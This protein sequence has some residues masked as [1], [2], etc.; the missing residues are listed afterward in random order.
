MNDIQ[1]ESGAG[2]PSFLP[3]RTVGAVASQTPTRKESFAIT[4]AAHAM[5]QGFLSTQ[6]SGPRRAREGALQHLEAMLRK[7]RM[8]GAR[9]GKHTI[10]RATHLEIKYT[11]FAPAPVFSAVDDE[12]L[13]PSK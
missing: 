4:Q 7:E 2:L 12:G 9:E 13:L 10:E 1:S 3:S 8:A 11:H 5:R 6:D